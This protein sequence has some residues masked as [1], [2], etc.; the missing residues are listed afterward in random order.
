MKN[1]PIVIQYGVYPMGNGQYRALVEL[2]P[3]C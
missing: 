1:Q 3:Y 2:R